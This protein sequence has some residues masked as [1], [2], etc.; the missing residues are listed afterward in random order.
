M[1]KRDVV[2]S[3]IESLMQQHLEADELVVTPTGEIPVRHRSA[4]YRVRIEPT[5]QPEPHVE[6]Y[7][8]AVDDVDA[9]PGLYEAL[10]TINS[11][12]SHARVFWVD[13]KIVV[14][15][16]LI[17]TSLDLPQLACACEEVSALAHHEGPRL[18]A[19]YGGRVADPSEIEEDR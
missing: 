4:L 11:R 1:S 17:G 15:A 9:D 8:V 18:A 2:Q 3:H 14:A 13:R 7:A 16:E 5:P 19:T 6:I 10:N 12:L